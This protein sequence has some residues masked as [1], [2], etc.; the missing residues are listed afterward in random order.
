MKNKSVLNSLF[1]IGAFL[2]LVFFYCEQ[3]TDIPDFGA[4][5]DTDTK[6]T[7]FF[8]F[9]SPMVKKENSRI[10]K[11]RERIL[12]VYQTAN[13]N[14]GISWRDRRWLNTLAKEYDILMEYSPDAAAWKLLLR[15][16]DTVP[17]ELALV[18]AAIE[19]AWGTSRFAKK[20]N[21][22]FG[23]HCQSE[24]CGII[25]DTQAEG[26]T[27]EVETF[28][29]VEDSVRSYIHNLNT[30]DAYSDLRSLRSKTRSSGK[31]PDGP[32]LATALHFYSE[33]RE[34][35]IRAVQ[36]M[37]AANRELMVEQ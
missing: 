2:L 11:Q 31:I 18:Q 36:N 32:T 1:F 7:K 9:L 30:N 8:N 10:R 6:K 33:R 29:S 34:D 20:G 12:S 22:F 17:L 24:G 13:D 16:V 4:I 28:A 15:R 14:A 21:N 3:K 5:Q 19:S 37:I 25:P 23:E 27:W 35:Y 26:H